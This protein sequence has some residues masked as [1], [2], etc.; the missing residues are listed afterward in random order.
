MKFNNILYLDDSETSY[1]RGIRNELQIISKRV[2]CYFYNDIYTAPIFL[3]RLN[4]KECQKQKDERIKQFISYIKKNQYDFILVGHPAIFPTYFFENLKIVFKN[5]PIVNY[6]WNSIQ[7]SNILPYCDYFTKV[8]SFDP[9]D[10]QKYGL[11]YYPLFYLKDFENVGIK[12]RKVF[13]MSFIG[14]VYNSGR[15]E[16]I[17]KWFQKIMILKLSHFLYLYAPGRLRGI[18]SKLRYRKMSNYFFFNEISM[19]EVINIFS[20]TDAMIDHQMNI[21]S[22]LTIRTFE[23]LGSGLN[24]YTTNEQILKEPFYNPERITIIDVNLGNFEFKNIIEAKID[25]DWQESF[26]K[27]RLDNWVKNI[28]SI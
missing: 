21:Q 24:L 16:F 7:M 26:K 17:N 2:D 22:G 20:V 4:P 14:S 19:N 25:K 27:Y 12:K 23:T 10:C 11:H 15:L 13:N 3:T 6:N 8:Y 5:I 1:T 9:Q 28:I 18:N